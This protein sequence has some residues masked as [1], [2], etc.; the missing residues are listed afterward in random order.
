MARQEDEI[1]PGEAPVAATQDVNRWCTHWRPQ[2]IDSKVGYA[3]SSGW[4]DC[5]DQVDAR[6][7]AAERESLARELFDRIA[8]ICHHE[9]MRREP[10]FAP[11][12][13]T[14]ARPHT[15]EMVDAT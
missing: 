5:S 11:I 1:V 6:G 9:A 15:S 4:E 3:F 8:A 13:G 2:T 7:R 14:S 10:H 12:L